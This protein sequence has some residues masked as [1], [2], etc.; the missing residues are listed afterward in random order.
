MEITFPAE[1]KLSQDSSDSNMSL[2]STVSVVQTLAM[3]IEGMS[4][5]LRMVEVN[6]KVDFSDKQVDFLLQLVKDKLYEIRNQENPAIVF[7]DN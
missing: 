5:V 2:Q 3:Y 6:D 1:I 7:E 4:Y